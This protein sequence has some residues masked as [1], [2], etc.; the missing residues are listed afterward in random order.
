MY[1]NICIMSIHYTHSYTHIYTLTCR[2]W[3]ART[4]YVV[5]CVRRT[6]YDV[7]IYSLIPVNVNPPPPMKTLKRHPRIRNGLPVD[8]PGKSDIH[9]R[10]ELQ[11]KHSDP[12][13]LAE[14]GELTLLLKRFVFTQISY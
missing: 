6:V 3:L 1:L 9:I 14:I 2:T 10:R 8:A 12:I 11:R 5:H 4:M 7:H 13:E